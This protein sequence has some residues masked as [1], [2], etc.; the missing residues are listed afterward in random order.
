MRLGHQ[1][2]RKTLETSNLFEFKN[3][4]KFHWKW[5]LFE[6]EL[7]WSFL[8]AI[9]KK[10]N[11]NW[12]D[13]AHKFF[14]SWCGGRNAI[15]RELITTKADQGQTSNNQNLLCQRID[16]MCTACSCGI[17]ISKIS[18][19]FSHLPVRQSEENMCFGPN[20]ECL[21][22][23][24]GRK[25]IF[26]KFNHFGPFCIAAVGSTIVYVVHMNEQQTF[27][28]WKIISAYILKLNCLYCYA[29]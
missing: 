20:L 6:I 24:C 18:H 3:K 22:P 2:A 17:M 7:L 8:K 23:R 12:T 4:N 27:I 14:L 5:N 9:Y 15:K 10:E 26:C 16:A 28:I 21:R 19:G 25:S 1:N 13:K 11:K 29:I